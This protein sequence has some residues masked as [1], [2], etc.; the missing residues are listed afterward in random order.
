MKLR[1]FHQLFWVVMLIL[2]IPFAA[3]A[4]NGKIVGK[5]TDA[6]TGD[7]LPG[8]NIFIEGTS[9]GAAADQSGKYVIYNVPPGKYT[10]RASFIGYDEAKKTVTVSAGAEV[11]ADFKLSMRVISGAS[12]TILADRATRETPVAF[13][14][15]SKLE[16]EARLGSRDIPLVLNTTPSVYATPQGGGAGDARINVR[17]FN[18]RN[19][20]IMINGV[21]VNDM[22]NGW[23]YWS[24]WDGVADATSSIQVQR[25]LSAV[26]LATPSIG[27]TMNVITTPTALEKGVAVKQEFGSGNFLKSTIIANSGMIN[28]KY[29]F[30]AA[31]VRKTGDGIIDKTWTDAWAYY[32]AASYQ[33]DPNN[34]VELYAVGAPQRHG[35]NLYKQ[36]IAVYSKEFAQNLDDYDPAAFDKFREKGRTFNQNWAP[37]SSSYKGKQFWVGK[38]HDRYDPNFINERENFYHKPLVN[39]NWYSKLS[40]RLNLFS[41]IYYSG[42]QGGGTGTFGTLVRNSADGPFDPR[43]GKFYYFASPWQWNWDATIAI[44]RDSTHAWIDKKEYNKEKGQSLGILRNSRN[45]Q[46]TIGAISKATYKVNENLVTNFGIDWR[47]AEI[48]HFR[49]VRDLLGG[50]YYFADH[51]DFWT[52]EEKKRKLGDKLDYYFTNTVDWLGGYGQGEYKK[53]P[54]SAYGMVGY[55][56]IKYSHTN[57]FR[58]DENGDELFVAT[59]W[60]GGGQ[61][62]GGASY[63]IREDFRIFGNVGFVSRVP[64]FDNV[65][66]DRTATKAENPKNEKFTSIEGGVDYAALGGKLALKANLYYTLW[67]DRARSVGVINPD[68]SEG[69][70]FIGG[71]DEQHAGFELEV[72]Y[73]PIPLIRLDGSVSIGNWKFVDDVSAVYK[74]Y[75]HGG[76]ED[77]SYNLYVKNLKVGDAPQTQFALVGTLRPVHGFQAQVVFRHYMQNYSNWDPFTRTDPDD[78][79]QSWQAPDYNV[80]DFHAKYDLPFT[81]SGMHIQFFGHVF[82]VLDELYIQDATDNSRYN[83]FGEK[84]HAA[85]DAEVFFGLPRY[86]N[87]GFKLSF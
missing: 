24:N 79:T 48:E 69:I 20:A 30:S 78:R 32:F 19:V 23:L 9:M 74:D 67:T 84:K 57:H 12:I 15:V 25:G 47:K 59:D 53:G 82:N 41:T 42:G 75:T 60:I 73:E 1:S 35:Q 31:I 85:D 6:R 87:V 29:A 50:T 40:D 55:S 66:N 49:E 43:T 3:Y 21:P 81:F 18:Q 36:N 86:F 5:V 37:V 76:A 80:L 4:V 56:V 52:P 8:T 2:A 44:N 7:P 34:R 17:G 39:L 64:I 13:T 33:M 26:N 68:G 22:E 83:A 72:A 28:G 61:A 46:W 10:L 58:M 38:S 14:N 11:R 16:M 65:I 54:I 27:G 77:V 62:K 45:N 51:S 71:L 70:I 63:R